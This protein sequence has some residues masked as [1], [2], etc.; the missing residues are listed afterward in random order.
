MNRDHLDKGFTL[1]EMLVVIVIIG[2]A[3]TVVIPM[4]GDN[5]DMQLTSA[6]RKLIT[7]LLWA[8]TVS[9]STQQRYQVVFDTAN[10][11]YEIQDQD[12]TV[13]NDPITKAPARMDY[14]VDNY[15]RSVE[16]A[17]ANFDGHNSVWFDRMGAPYSGA[18]IDNTPLTSGQIVLAGG[19]QT[20]TVNVEP[21]TGR[22]TSP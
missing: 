15:L 22:I 7:D 21:V 10:E 19:E 2:I 20:V 12:G 16:I 1:V 17:T 18:I 8:Q 11:T 6:S 4:I 13:I 9:I 14:T 3:A 5:S